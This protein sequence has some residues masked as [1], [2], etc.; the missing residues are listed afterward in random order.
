MQGSTLC[1]PQRSN[2]KHGMTKPKTNYF[3]VRANGRTIAR[4]EQ[5][6]DAEA[7][8]LEVKAPSRPDVDYESVKVERAAL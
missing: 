5:K 1:K 7:F 8:I 4:F 6:L 3:E 2:G